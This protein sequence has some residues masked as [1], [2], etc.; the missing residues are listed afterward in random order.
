MRITVSNASTVTSFRSNDTNVLQRQS[1]HN[2]KTVYES[3]FRLF[4][5]AGH[6][7][8]RGYSNS[9]NV[10]PSLSV[11]LSVCISC[12]TFCM[13]RQGL[14]PGSPNLVCI[15]P[16]APYLRW[17]LLLIQKVKSQGRVTLSEWLSVVQMQ[18]RLGFT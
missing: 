5:K 6:E 3:D 15:D 13:L 7:L 11:C 8:Q 10:C 17:L 14:K 16:K 2:P 1:V 12:T 18:R 4:R 9:F